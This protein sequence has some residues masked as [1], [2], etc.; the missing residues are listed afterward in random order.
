M[1]TP[2]IEE[3]REKLQ[4]REKY[5]EVCKQINK[6]CH[7]SLSDADQRAALKSLNLSDV[8]I[9][10][11]LNTDEYPYKKGVESYVLRNNNAEIRRLKERIKIL[12]GYSEKEDENI[13]FE[14]GYISLLYSE[15][16]IKVFFPSKPAA[17]IREAL[18]KYSFHWSPKEGVWRRKITSHALD[19]TKWYLTK[20]LGF[21]MD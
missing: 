8:A 12:E 13:P 4:T 2:T 19:D 17:E 6:I 16:V 10:K 20:I 15:S 11:L 3:L 7:S 5:Q 14:N 21:T 9:E 1:A 18:K